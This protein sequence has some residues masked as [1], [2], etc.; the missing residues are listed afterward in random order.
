[1]TAL[2]NLQQ[3]HTDGTDVKKNNP[4]SS[5]HLNDNHASSG[6]KISNM[7]VYANGNTLT[8]FV[9][10]RSISICCSLITQI[11]YDSLDL[12]QRMSILGYRFDLIE[13]RDCILR[14]LTFA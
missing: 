9:T 2:D 12:C 8:V 7:S 1:M 13:Q 10:L 6:L 4:R 14:G 5:A 3:S 11:I